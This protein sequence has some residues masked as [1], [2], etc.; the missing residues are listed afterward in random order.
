MKSQL[1][2][3]LVALLGLTLGLSACSSDDDPAETPTPDSTVADTAPSDAGTADGAD[4]GDVQ[5]PP[6]EGPPPAPTSGP[7]VYQITAEHTDDLAPGD[8]AG[9]RI[10]DWVI[11]NDHLRAVIRGGSQGLYTAGTGGGG[12]VDIGSPT[13]DRVQEI[14]PV[15]G[16]N[17]FSGEAQ[18]TVHD[19]GNGGSASLEVRS[20]AGVPALVAAWI[21]SLGLD[22]DIVQTYRLEADSR[23]LEITTTLDGPSGEQEQLVGDIAF[24]GGEIEIRLREADGW[25]VAEGPDVSYGLVSDEELT[26]LELGGLSAVMG[27]ALNPVTWT[28]WFVVGDGSMSSVV[29]ELIRIRMAPHGTVSGTVSEPGVAVDVRDDNGE[30]VSRFR[31]DENGAF[32]GLLPV[33]LYD[34]IAAGPGRQPGAPV[35]VDII[36]GAEL[37]DLA[38]AAEPAASITLELDMPMRIHAMSPG[39]HV[40][41]HLAPGTQ[42]LPVPPGTYQL[43]ATRGFEYEIDRTEVTVEAGGTAS[44]TPVLV[45]SVDTT[46]WIAADFH[47]HSEWSVDSN[48][49]LRQRILSCAAEGVEYAVATDHDVITDYAPFVLPSIADHIVVAQGVEISTQPWGHINVW[50]LERDVDKTG[51]GSIPWFQ[52]DLDGL[53]DVLAPETPGRVVQI[54]HGRE[55]SGLFDLS[56]YDSFAPQPDLI[57]SYRFTAMELF[58]SGGGDFDELLADWLSL[59]ME[60]EDV[61]ATGVSDSHS[62]GSYCGHARTFIQVDGE[63]PDLKGPEIDSQI[64]ARRTMVSSGPFATLEEGTD[65]AVHLRIQAPSWMPVEYANIYVDGVLDTE[66]VIDP[67][68]EV[69]RFDQD[70]TLQ[71][72]AGKQIVAVVG[73]QS[74]PGPMLKSKLR[75][76]TPLLQR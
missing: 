5:D 53:M 75:T 51:F 19:D 23:A 62:L 50:P 2:L 24:L 28:R 38:V 17:S 1:K 18:M 34:L 66:V 60:G 64:L 74:G 70:L 16:F 15:V 40:W 30:L 13:A 36:D 11:A 22:G 56:D 73:A 10:G 59:R 32:S 67:S 49:P 71:A 57:E 4:T 25:M 39:A 6:D 54:N 7:R 42:T 55:G 35:P 58:N 69:I 48:I 44:W 65:G 72:T 76:V 27:P 31:T 14:I 47:L 61:A 8:L 21:P 63:V 43:T 45:R 26:V 41:R 3:G 12:I 37:S 52:L 20:V 68:T 9:A 33:G 29:D 46:G